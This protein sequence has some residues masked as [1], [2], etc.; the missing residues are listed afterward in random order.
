MINCVLLFLCSIV[1]KFVLSKLICVKTLCEG[2]FND[3]NILFLNKLPPKTIVMKKI[4]IIF[5]IFGRNWVSFLV[6]G[7]ASIIKWQIRCKNVRYS[8]LFNLTKPFTVMLEISGSQ[9]NVAVFSNYSLLAG[10]KDFTFPTQVIFTVRVW[11]QKHKSVRGQIVF[12]SFQRPL[13]V[14]FLL[15]SVLSWSGHISKG[16]SEN[17]IFRKI[18][19]ISSV[20]A[21]GPNI[22]HFFLFYYIISMLVCA[23]FRLFHKA[24][25]LQHP[26]THQ[27]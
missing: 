8:N 22:S 14:T 3:K 20:G 17:Q 24:A 7:E 4:Y 27:R 11:R 26:R 16:H 18:K 5:K 19:N 23:V 1:L 10:P 6:I 12:Q 13:Q 2:A 25:I 9:F 15:W 21:G